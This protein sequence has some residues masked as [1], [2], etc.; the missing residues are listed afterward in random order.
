MTRKASTVIAL[1]SQVLPLL[2]SKCNQHLHYAEGRKGGEGEGG[3]GDDHLA[4]QVAKFVNPLQHHSDI[5]PKCFGF[6]QEPSFTCKGLWLCCHLT[7]C[8]HCSILHMT[9]SINMCRWLNAQVNAQ[10]LRKASMWMH[11]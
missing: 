3:R 5:P 7:T 9:E 2:P 11:V 6:A 10:L 1:Y 4:K 8:I